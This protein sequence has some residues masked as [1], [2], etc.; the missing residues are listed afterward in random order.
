MGADLHLVV[1]ADP[2]SGKLLR[3]QLGAWMTSAGVAGRS[4]M[5]IAT[6]VTE[7]FLNAVAH[8]LEREDD[9]VVVDCELVSGQLVIRIADHG[10]WKEPSGD[11]ER[12]GFRLM[13]G[14]MDS[15]AVERVPAGTVVTLRRTVAGRGYGRPAP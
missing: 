12:Y 7:A 14:L 2:A 3:A 10:R 9:D 8:P 13:E 5:A 4:G 1:P 6:A 15:V 11:G